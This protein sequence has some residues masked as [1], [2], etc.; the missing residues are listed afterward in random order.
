MVAISVSTEGK[1][2][3][4][5]VSSEDLCPMMP[6][7]ESRGRLLGLS[8]AAGVGGVM[9]ARGAPGPLNTARRRLPRILK[10]HDENS[11]LV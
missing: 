6:S 9:I 2:E 11:N 7:A 10:S 8:R 1:E 3:A 5:D 4:V